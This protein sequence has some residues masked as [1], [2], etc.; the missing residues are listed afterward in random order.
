MLCS[1]M[2]YLFLY[3]SFII[4]RTINRLYETVIDSDS[5]YLKIL[6]G[7]YDY[8]EH[9]DVTLAALAIVDHKY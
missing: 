5:D 7:E 3:L 4:F 6:K 2:S 8:G 1:R 9:T